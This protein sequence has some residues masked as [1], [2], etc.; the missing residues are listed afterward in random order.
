MLGFVRLLAANSLLLLFAFPAAAK[1]DTVVYRPGVKRARGPLY[2]PAGKGPFPAVLMIHGDHGLTPWVKNQ[3]RRLAGKG[4]L[5][6]A[7]DLYGGDTASEEL[8]AHILGRGLPDDQ[9]RA[10]LKAAVEYLLRRPDVKKDAM[11]GL[12]W[13]I[14]GGYALDLAIA[15]PRLKA[16]VVC[17]GRL[18][19]DAEV[20]KPLGAS[21]LGI[22]AGRDEGISPDVVARFQKAMRTAGKRLTVHTYAESG[23]GFMEAEGNS[24]ADAWQKIESFLAAELRPES[25]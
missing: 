23:H 12:G 1:E 6:L 9:V 20:L 16:A 5:T 17:Y 25:R 22:F 10:D 19:T 13:D 21:V 3:A 2:H 24:T 18:T 14:G 8:D 15:D 11:G 4:Y 7:V